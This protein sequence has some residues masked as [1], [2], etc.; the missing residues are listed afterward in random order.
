[1]IKQSMFSD[2]THQTL[3]VVT[4]AF[5]C[6]TLGTVISRRYYIWEKYN[7]LTQKR[8]YIHPLFNIAKN[9]NTN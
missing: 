6:I 4:N 7:E 3:M 1:M 2:S 8:K 9:G 5:L